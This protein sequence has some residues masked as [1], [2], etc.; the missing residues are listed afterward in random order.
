M[1]AFK[2]QVKLYLDGGKHPGLSEFIP[3]FHGFIKHKKLGELLIDVANYAHVPEGPG[4]ALIGHAHDYFLDESEARPGLLASRKRDPLPS[5]E[6]LRDIF[7]RAINTAILL[8]KDPVLAG[9]IHFRTDEFLF[10]INDR[11]GAPNTDA[12]FATVRPAI[13]SLAARLFGAA[14]VNIVRVG[15]GRELFSVRITGAA[16]ADLATL[17][18]RLGGGADL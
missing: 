15:T 18:K 16:S 10:R 8:E 9:K 7:R 3:V 6:R 14:A 12:T 17:L 5:S 1:D 2:L 11:L 13:D 4:V